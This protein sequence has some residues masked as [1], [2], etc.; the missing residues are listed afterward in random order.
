MHAG[1]LRNIKEISGDSGIGTVERRRRKTAA[2]YQD[3]QERD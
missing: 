1:S 2:K 3:D